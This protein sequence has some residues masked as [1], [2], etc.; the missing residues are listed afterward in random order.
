L[1]A[2]LGIEKCAQVLAG[3]LENNID[4]NT[5]IKHIESIQKMKALNAAMLTTLKDK[6]FQF[7]GKD[8]Q[9]NFIT[10][11]TEAHL[12]TLPRPEQV[13]DALQPKFALETVLYVNALQENK[14]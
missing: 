5:A 12:T 1:A 10:K 11:H 7:M 3:T 4:D 2:N 14:Q 6:D 13:K 8:D 9:S